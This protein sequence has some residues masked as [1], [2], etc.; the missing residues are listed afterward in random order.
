MSDIFHFYLFLLNSWKIL[1]VILNSTHMLTI[2]TATFKEKEIP[3]SHLSSTLWE[4]HR[5]WLQI[6]LSPI[7]WALKALLSIPFPFL[8]ISR[9][10]LETPSA[11]EPQCQNVPGLRWIFTFLPVLRCVLS[12]LSQPCSRC[13]PL[14][15]HQL[16][17]LETPTHD[18][19]PVNPWP[20]HSCPSQACCKVKMGP[21]DR[22]TL[23]KKGK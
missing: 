12:S 7:L 9:L 21:G 17:S 6:Q 3:S 16:H 14:L 2:T 19:K 22:G 1:Y 18:T 5:T 15:P 4:L 11:W 20:F 13:L 23:P 8:C 10:F